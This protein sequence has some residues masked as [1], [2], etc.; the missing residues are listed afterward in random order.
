[1][2]AVPGLGQLVE[3][4]EELGPRRRGFATVDSR[5]QRCRFLY[6]CSQK[7][8]ATLSST[9]PF[10]SIWFHLLGRTD[11]ALPFSALPSASVLGVNSVSRR[12]EREEEIF[13]RN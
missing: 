3:S 8:S 6:I 13:R 10:R 7:S 1:M 11:C 5:Q 12:G 9:V 4:V 2:K